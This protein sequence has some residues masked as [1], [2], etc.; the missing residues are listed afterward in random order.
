MST[1]LVFL[2]E[3]LGGR[4]YEF[5]TEKTSV[6]RGD[7][8]TLAIRDDSVSSAHCEILVNG[9]EVIV[10]ELGSANGTYVNDVAVVGQREVK[11]G[12]VLRFGSIEARLELDP[13][14]WEETTTEET[15]V[16][17][18]QRIIR[19]QRRERNKP[20]PADP[21]MTLESGTGAEL[22]DHTVLLMRPLAPLEAK[23]ARSPEPA[24]S[25]SSPSPWRMVPALAILLGLAVLVCWLV[26]W[27]K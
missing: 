13:Q 12:Q 8:N 23:P 11:N 21:S 24:P 10:R 17:E 7:H 2:G 26:W 22:G 1:K 15:A 6:G 9:P 14:K 16:Y 19:D 25:R 4:V 18:M 5:V 27:R 20:K 3:K